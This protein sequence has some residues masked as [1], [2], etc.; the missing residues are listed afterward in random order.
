MAL[1]V[2]HSAGPPLA[3]IR[4]RGCRIAMAYFAPPVPAPRADVLRLRSAHERPAG[5]VTSFF[6]L[7]LDL[8]RPLDAL[9]AAIKNRTR[10][11]IRQAEARDGL[12][13][14]VARAAEPGVLDQ[15]LAFYDRFAASRGLPAPERD[16]LAGLAANGGLDLS[17]VVADSEVLVWHAHCR[18]GDRAMLLASASHFRAVDDSA[19][20]NRIGRANRFHH[21]SDIQRF[22][23][24]GLGV[25]DFGGWYEGTTDEARLRINR[26]KEEFGGT[27]A[28]H[29]DAEMPLTVR[30]RLALRFGDWL[31]RRRR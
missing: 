1:S 12:G 9:R 8:R 21:W 18:N 30:G 7:L 28:E 6:T 26:F 31:R 19:A 20:R 14:R 29:F 24:E 4:R 27:V 25:Y 11:A 5:P 15:F 23:A 13:Y 3:L 16:V 10:E 17:A 2:P 22:R